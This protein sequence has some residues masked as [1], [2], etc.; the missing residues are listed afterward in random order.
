MTGFPFQETYLLYFL[1]YVV[2][3]MVGVGVMLCIGYVFSTDREE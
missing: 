2:G 3:L 1:A